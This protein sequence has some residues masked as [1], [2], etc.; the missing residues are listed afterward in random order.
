VLKPRFG[1]WG[2]DLMLCRTVDELDRCLAVQ[3]E[4]PWFHRHGVLIQE[5]I[6]PA[7]HDLRITV[8]GSHV[9]GA[10]RRDAAPGEWRT[11]VTLGGRAEPARPSRRPVRSRLTPL[12]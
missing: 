3:R 5:L 4:R 9:V 10:T 7:G 6:P 2:K 11:N 1:S 8:A 12:A